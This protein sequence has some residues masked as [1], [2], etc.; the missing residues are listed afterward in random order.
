L[1]LRLLLTELYDLLLKPIESEIVD[2]RTIAVLPHDWLNYLPF[3]ALIRKDSSDQQARFF[4]QNKKIVYLTSRTSVNL[5]QKLAKDRGEVPINSVVAFGN[6]DLGFNDRNLV[7]GEIEAAGQLTAPFEPAERLNRFA[8]LPCAEK[9]VENIKKYFPNSVILTREKASKENFLNHWNQHA[10]IHVAAH[11]KL[12][13]RG[14][15]LLLAPEEKGT[16]T[17]REI[18]RLNKAYH[19]KTTRFIALSACQ[20]AIDPFLR[21]KV[22]MGS[23]SAIE[24]A[25]ALA[26]TV[27][28]FLYVG[29]PAIVATLWSISD[30]G[31]PLLMDTFYHNLKEGHTFLDAFRDA[32]L[33]MIQ[34]NDRFSQPYY[35]AGFVY[36]GL[37]D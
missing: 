34:R 1:E 16:L 19:N 35:W 13:E 23:K 17:R 9:E 11:A 3:E 15:E 14:S 26:G 7:C 6:P 5:I 22:N 2:S 30:E 10:I 27:H 32:R 29:V 24:P 33:Q 36:F 20:T 8:P 25:T 12:T 18:I 28:G 31:T 37:P 4:I 21:S